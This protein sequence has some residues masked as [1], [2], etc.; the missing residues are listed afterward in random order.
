[1]IERLRRPLA[2][3]LVAA[4]LMLLVPPWAACAQDASDPVA[5]LMERMSSAA[6][7]GQLF[8]VTFPG[9]EVTD[10]A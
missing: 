5:Q 7:V 6:K 1:M 3:A 4:T 8:L 10:D 9:A 2:L